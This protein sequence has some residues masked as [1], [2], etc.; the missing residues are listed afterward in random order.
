VA[1][2]NLMILCDTN[3]I[4]E[5]LTLMLAT[6]PH[7]YTQTRYFSPDDNVGRKPYGLRQQNKLDRYSRE[8]Y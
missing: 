8:Q 3:V 7:G 6:D 4:I 1:E 5:T 2:K